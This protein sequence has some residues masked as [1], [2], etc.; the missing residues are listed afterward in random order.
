[1]K[2]KQYDT[3]R[4]YATVEKDQTRRNIGVQAFE[5]KSLY[6]GLCQL[7]G[8]FSSFGCSLSVGD[9]ENSIQITRCVE[10]RPGKC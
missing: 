5:S 8:N 4:K 7:L 2:E 1:M 3:F 9:I 6:F 10:G